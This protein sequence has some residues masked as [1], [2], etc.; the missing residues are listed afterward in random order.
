MVMYMRHDA[1]L[2]GKIFVLYEH[3]RE[4]SQPNQYQLEAR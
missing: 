3:F 2:T 4:E 1:R